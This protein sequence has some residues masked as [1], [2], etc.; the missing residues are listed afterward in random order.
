VL[1]ALG[2]RA[3]TLDQLVLRTGLPLEAVARHTTDLEAAGW[4]AADGG[5]FERRR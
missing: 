1:D 4:L 5:W 3:R 2:W